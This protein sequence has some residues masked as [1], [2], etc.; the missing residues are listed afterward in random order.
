MPS[1]S[2]LSKPVFKGIPR[3]SRAGSGLCL[4]GG[5]GLCLSRAT[6][7]SAELIRM[8]RARATPRLQEPRSIPAIVIRSTVPAMTS[9]S[10]VTRSANCRTSAGPKSI[11]S[12]V[13]RVPLSERV[14]RCTDNA[15]SAKGDTRDPTN[16]ASSAAAR[17]TV[18][19]NSNERPSS[20]NSCDPTL[21]D[22]GSRTALRKSTM[23]SSAARNPWN[24]E[25][26]DRVAV[27]VF[28]W[29]SRS[30]PWIIKRS[31]STTPFMNN[32]R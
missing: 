30:V 1:T 22:S 28:S 16:K 19:P 20:L 14:I 15:E 13:I 17:N 4:N 27:S 3:R 6:C 5:S 29:T 24:C 8:E 26:V 21:M 10:R 2:T 12:M 11:P 18:S 31:I 32:R 7:R 9:R 23:F 25:S